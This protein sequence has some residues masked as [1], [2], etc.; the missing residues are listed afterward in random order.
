MA[1]QFIGQIL[2]GIIVG[3]ILLVGPSVAVF[4]GW[5]E[6]RSKI[7][8]G[9]F[10]MTRRIAASLGILSITAQTVLFISLLGAIIHYKVLGPY[11]AVLFRCVFA[12]LLLALLAAPCTFALRGRTRWWLLASSLLFASDFVFL[13]PCNFGLLIPDRIGI[14]LHCAFLG[15]GS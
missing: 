10:P 9:E 6:W 11:S 5:S 3:G 7:C 14:S 4:Y 12:E 15:L 13:R 1:Y 2:A 8:K